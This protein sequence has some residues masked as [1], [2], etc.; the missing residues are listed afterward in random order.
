MNQS[1]REIV[2]YPTGILRTIMRLPLVLHRLGLGPLVNLLPLLVI[3]TRG[4]SSGLPRQSVLEYR[5]HGNRFYVVSVW[6]KRTQW[7]QNLIVNPLVTV[8]K[9]RERFGARAALVSDSGEALRVLYLFRK[10]APIIYDALLSRLSDQGTVNARTLPDIA[11]QFVIVRLEPTVDD[12]AP[13]PLPSDLAWIW[14]T[15]LMAGLALMAIRLVRR[16]SSR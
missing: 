15:A 14:R 10:K 3:T 13:P 1:G 12:S 2:P 16:A 8:Q 11:N 6:G 4:R 9:G 7:F 5:R